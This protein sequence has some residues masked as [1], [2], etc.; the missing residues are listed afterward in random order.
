MPKNGLNCINK[1]I[2]C[3]PED[4]RNYAMLGFYYY[5]KGFPD[6]IALLR[7]SDSLYE[8]SQRLT[9]DYGYQYYQRALVKFRLKEFREAW[10]NIE[11]ARALNV[12][13]NQFYQPFMDEL[14]AAFPYKL[15]LES[16]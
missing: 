7:Q 2:E 3:N 16:K 14:E 10:D 4:G 12:Q 6:Q 5:D 11:M 15:Y 9:P 8:I 1:L 13:E